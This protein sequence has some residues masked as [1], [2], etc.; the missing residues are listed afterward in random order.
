[1]IRGA[2]VFAVGLGLGYAKAVSELDA[3]RGAAVT[4][5]EFFVEAAQKEGFY[6]A[7]DAE[8]EGVHYLISRLHDALDQVGS[9]SDD[10]PVLKNDADETL[11]TVGDL[12]APFSLG[13]Y[14]SEKTTTKQGESS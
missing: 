3:V 11:I 7:K 2:F 10:E 8:P 5:K 4:F 12:R 1:M 14:G 9:V 13:P 6:P